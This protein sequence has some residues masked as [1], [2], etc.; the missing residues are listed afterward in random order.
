M[1]VK[2]VKRTLTKFE[3]FGVSFELTAFPAELKKADEDDPN[4][5]YDYG[6]EYLAI[7]FRIKH[8]HKSL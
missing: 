8:S 2:N 6:D 7:Y 1:E 4:I 5:D 3:Y